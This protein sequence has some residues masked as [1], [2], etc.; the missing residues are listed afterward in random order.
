MAEDGQ[1]H[2]FFLLAQELFIFP[3]GLALVAVAD[4]RDTGACSL[5]ATPGK[6]P[7]TANVIVGCS[8]GPVFPAA[9]LR[10]AS[11]TPPRRN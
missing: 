6:Q 2:M 10:R 9:Q 7:T 4:L 11:A 5:L 1:Y 8:P 3:N